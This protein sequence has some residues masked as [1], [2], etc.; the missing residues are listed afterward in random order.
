ML[1][2]IE[3]MKDTIMLVLKLPKWDV[4]REKDAQNVETGWFTTKTCSK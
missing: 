2:N 1:Q 4:C 3:S